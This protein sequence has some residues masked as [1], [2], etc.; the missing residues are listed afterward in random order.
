MVYLVNKYIIQ[1]NMN[2]L[3]KKG[4]S[5]VL[6]FLMS[7][8]SLNVGFLG[9]GMTRVFAGGSGYINQPKSGNTIY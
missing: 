8:G 3:F 6:V 9:L 2:K 7:L 5:F 4:I 1:E